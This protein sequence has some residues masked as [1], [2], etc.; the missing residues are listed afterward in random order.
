MNYIVAAMILLGLFIYISVVTL[1][2]IWVK[3]KISYW[4]A[5][6]RQA[7][8]KVNRADHNAVEPVNWKE[9]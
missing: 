8:R 6:R 2:T 4:L 9:L 3:N 1:I 7:K 5:R